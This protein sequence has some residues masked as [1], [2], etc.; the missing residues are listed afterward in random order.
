MRKGKLKVTES[1]LHGGKGGEEIV[2]QSFPE[3]Q[4][5][6][7]LMG[8]RTCYPK[9]RHL[10]ILNILSWQSLRAWKK[11]EVPFDHLPILLPWN[12]S[13]FSHERRPPYTCR[14]RTSSS[15]KTKIWEESNKLTLLSFPQFTVLTSCPLTYPI[16]PWLSLFIKPSIKTPSPCCLSGFL[17]P[18]EVSYVIA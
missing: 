12:R 8:F 10:S 5:L 9:T 16:A 18:Y 3:K 13:F 1:A 4:L 6:G 14:R 7:R 17:F 15:P 2:R 11:Q